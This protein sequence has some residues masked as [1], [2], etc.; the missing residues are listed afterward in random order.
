MSQATSCGH[1]LCAGLIQYL[2]WSAGAD[3]EPPWKSYAVVRGV[4]AACVDE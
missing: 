3:F 4:N 2:N 1:G